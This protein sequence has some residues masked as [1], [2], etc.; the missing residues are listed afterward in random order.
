VQ[1]P[2][3]YFPIEQ[4]FLIPMFQFLPFPIRVHLIRRFNISWF[5]RI[6][7]RAQAETFLHSFRLLSCRELRTLFPNAEIYRE[8]FCGLTKSFMV[9]GG[10]QARA[11]A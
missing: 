1:T 5:E 3:K 8:R 11:V 2:N 6:P 4:H 7:D 9:L 10:W